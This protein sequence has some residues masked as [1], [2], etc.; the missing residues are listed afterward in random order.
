M[1]MGTTRLTKE[2]LARRLD[3]VEYPLHRS[4]AF[5]DNKIGALK[6]RLVIACGYSDDI[7]DFRGAID[8]EQNAGSYLVDRVGMLPNAS[9]FAAPVAANPNTPNITRLRDYFRREAGAKK[10]KSVWDAGGIP[11][12]FETDI[13]HATFNVM[14]GGDVFCR[15]IVF[16]LDDLGPDADPAGAPSTDA[17]NAIRAAH[18]AVGEALAALD[19]ALKLISNDRGDQ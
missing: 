15:A 16:S 10:I 2:E 1:T 8:G 13:P 4:E 18:T 19:R 12:S 17:V 7:C 9:S 5:E 6:A 14:K 3:G 11:W